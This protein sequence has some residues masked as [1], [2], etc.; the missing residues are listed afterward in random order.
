[1]HTLYSLGATE[2]Y[3]QQEANIHDSAEAGEQTDIYIESLV[4]AD[5]LDIDM[6]LE[7]IENETYAVAEVSAFLN[8]LTFF[9][10]FFY[11]CEIRI[12]IAT[13][14]DYYL[15]NLF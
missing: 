15:Q 13:H 5:I 11:N 2:Y 10:A 8:D 14:C 7:Q 1:M 9:Y 6:D 12:V 3:I 4:L